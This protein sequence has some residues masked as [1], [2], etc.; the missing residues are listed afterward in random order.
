M[1]L[2]VGATG[3]VLLAASAVQAAPVQGLWST[4]TRG[5]VVR[6][7][8]CGPLI[9]GTLEDAPDLRADPGA[10]DQRNRDP[11]K[12]NRPLKGVTLL[13]GFRGGPGR[14]TGGVIYNPED[15]R[16]YRSELI[17]AD[18]RTLKVRG[19]FGPICR[20]QTWTRLR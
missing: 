11:A 10:T 5:G 18:A 6:I 8:P 17:L 12:R 9:C 19:C 16:T 1:I 7:E 4:E 13:S 15:G 14:W 2:A 3:A 20:T